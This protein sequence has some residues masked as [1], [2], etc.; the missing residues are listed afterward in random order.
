MTSAQVHEKA[1]KPSLN[2][3]FV[4]YGGFETNSSLHLHGFANGLTR[5]GHRCFIAA[6]NMKRDPEGPGGPL[7]Q[8]G[9]YETVIASAG[10]VFED[11]TP[12]VIHAWTPREPIRRFLEGLKPFLPECKRIIHLE[13]NEQFLSQHLAKVQLPCFNAWPDFI[14]DRV[15]HKNFSHPA[16]AK[17]LLAE[18]DGISV[19]WESLRAQAPA[20][21]PILELWPGLDWEEFQ[22]LEPKEILR[23]RL[24][25]DPNTKLI[26][27][28]GSLNQVNEREQR[29]LYQAVKLMNERGTPCHL[30]R[31]GIHSDNSGKHL[32]V[33]LGHRLTDLGEVPRTQ[34]LSWVNASDALV[35]PGASDDFNQF[36]FPCKLPEYLAMGHPVILPAANL[37]LALKDREEAWV[38]QTG[39]AEEI[40]FAC[41][42]IFADPDLGAKMGTAGREFARRT[43]S[44]ERST[45]ELERFYLQLLDGTQPR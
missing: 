1:F 13:D 20:G 43:F 17:R 39:S 23:A 27:Y 36:R 24:G 19:I 26:V 5:R 29:T 40:F 4:N 2:I 14:L 35:Q 22:N 3:L 21:K 8:Y 6:S 42:T 30:V 18:V 11:S 25:L 44:W 34:M 12:D 10:Q 7:Y 37:G 33:D 45:E 9:D 15:I 32:G 41:Q 31:T 38:L 16:R 28:S